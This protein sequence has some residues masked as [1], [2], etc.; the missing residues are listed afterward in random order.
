MISAIPPRS[1]TPRTPQRRQRAIHA[2]V[3]AEL[4]RRGS[5]PAMR[6]SARSQRRRHR[7][8][9]TKLAREPRESPA[10]FAA[11]Q[12]GGDGRIVNFDDVDG[13]VERRAV[14]HG[15]NALVR[16]R[17]SAGSGVLRR[18][19]FATAAPLP[20]VGEI[21]SA[22]ISFSPETPIRCGRRWQSTTIDTYEM[23]ALAQR[24]YAEF[25]QKLLLQFASTFASARTG[26]V[27]QVAAHFQLFVVGAEAEA[28]PVHSCR[29]R[30]RGC[31]RLPVGLRPS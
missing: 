2:I 24:T 17:R 5:H 15:G 7:P 16:W 22:L 6:C 21:V 23:T 13:P 25:A 9:A 28:N 3:G 1:R 14:A 26:G 20:P 18:S 11:E 8:S 10:E 12:L 29:W 30:R 31:R 27:A 4:R 19:L